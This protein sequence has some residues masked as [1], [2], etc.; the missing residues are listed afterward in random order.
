MH[1]IACN[2]LFKGGNGRVNLITFN[3][4]FLDAGSSVVVNKL[5]VI[6]LNLPVTMTVNNPSQKL[7]INTSHKWVFDL[8]NTSGIENLMASS[9]IIITPAVVTDVINVRAG[10]ILKEV[11]VY[12]INGKLIDKFTPDS[13]EATLNLSHLIDGIYFV[14][15]RTYSGARAIKQI[16]KR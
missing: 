1:I 13:N 5:Q 9:S 4:A 10:D 7:Q 3:T 6:N 15:A 2:T 11:N 8:N 12:S 14:E 16:L